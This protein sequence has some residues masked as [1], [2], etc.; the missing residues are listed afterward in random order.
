MKNF[1]E[2]VLALPVVGDF[3]GT[4]GEMFTEL[5]CKV[6]M[7]G[8]G[9]SGK[10]PWGNGGWKYSVYATLIEGGFIKGRLDE[11][12]FVKWVEDTREVDKALVALVKEWG[13]V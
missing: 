6:W 3:E 5:A 8:E 1:D 11:D 10:R 2:S 9:F 12:G 13:I 4:V 7:E